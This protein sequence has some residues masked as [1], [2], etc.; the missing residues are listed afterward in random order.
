MFPN[1]LLLAFDSLLINKHSLRYQDKV[2]EF[3]SYNSTD[4]PQFFEIIIKI[5]SPMTISFSTIDLHSLFK[6][7]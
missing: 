3:P 4:N 5:K 2:A 6:F 1:P 7:R